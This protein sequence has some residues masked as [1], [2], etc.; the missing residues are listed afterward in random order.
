VLHRSLCFAPRIHERLLDALFRLDDRSQPLAEINRRLGAEAERL[1][2][3]RPSYQRVRVLL[4]LVRQMRRRRPAPTTA[5]IL[6]DVWLRVRPVGHFVEHIYG[7][8]VPPLPP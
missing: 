8:T 1:R 7:G 5:R 6:Y 3:T 4:H 2:L